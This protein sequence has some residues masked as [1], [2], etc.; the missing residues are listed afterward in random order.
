MAYRQI[1]V[2]LGQHAAVEAGVVGCYQD[3]R[4]DRCAVARHEPLFPVDWA[5]RLDHYFTD[6][7]LHVADGAGHFTLIEC[8]EQFAELILAQQ[9]T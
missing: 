9:P 4:P 5:D 8:T 3:S 6:A 1:H 2:G 7:R